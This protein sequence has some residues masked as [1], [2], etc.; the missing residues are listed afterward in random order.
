MNNPLYRII[1]CL[2]VLLVFSIISCNNNN[3]QQQGEET[4]A[5]TTDSLT[6]IDNPGQAE[7]VDLKEDVPPKEEKSAS[8]KLSKEEAQKNA[9][10]TISEPKRVERTQQA[11]KNIEVTFHDCIG[12]MSVTE[13]QF[14]NADGQILKFKVPMNASERTF[15]VPNDLAMPWTAESKK[16]GTRGV[17]PEKVGQAYIIVTDANG[18]LVAIKP[19]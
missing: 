7:T 12:N 18:K 16:T 14:K 3:D 11:A 19:K 6:T 8:P 4:T 1:S 13:Y 9:T 2:A 17:N 5:G 15:D 10:P